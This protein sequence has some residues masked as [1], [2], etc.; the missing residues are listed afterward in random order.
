MTACGRDTACDTESARCDTESAR[1][2]TAGHDHDTAPVGA[3]TR[4]N[5]RCNT[6]LCTRHGRSARAACAA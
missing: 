2:D 5:A 3:T 4:P 6:A 1:C